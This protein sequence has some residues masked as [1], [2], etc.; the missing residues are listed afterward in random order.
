MQI[1]AIAW[2]AFGATEIT[3]S[4]AWVFASGIATFKLLLAVAYI[5]CW[6]WQG[7]RAL[8]RDYAL[9]Y[10]I[11]AVLWAL[12]IGCSE[13][14]RWV[15]WSLAF[16]LDLIFPWWVARYTY[17][18]PP[19]PEHLPERFGLFTIILLGEGM[20]STVHALNHGP[21]LSMHAFIAALGG[22][23][24]A[25]MTWVGYFDQA[26]AQQERHV[27]D[28]RAGRNFRLWAHAHVALYLG[29]ASLAAGT[30][31]FAGATHMLY[32]EYLVF[33]LGV[34]LV[35]L[36]LNLI[37]VANTPGPRQPVW[38][39]SMLGLGSSLVYLALMSVLGISN[40]MQLY[41]ASGCALLT[42]LALLAL[43]RPAR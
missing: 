7:A 12:S 19:H 4:R 34:A 37:H 43:F 29:I 25:F 16:T 22:A 39:R 30:V 40:T 38:L 27:A 21:H 23:L 41:L 1:L 28:G 24:L 6:R 32:Q 5:T 3:G 33:A 2:V 14:V 31:H 13:S 26:R 35:G 36:G 20:A 15:L 17:R 42:Q 11:Q 8:I 10:I 18:I 9:L